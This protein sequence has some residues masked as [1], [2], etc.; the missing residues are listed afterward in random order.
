MSPGCAA[1]TWLHLCCVRFLLQVQAGGGKERVPFASRMIAFHTSSASRLSLPCAP[2]FLSTSFRPGL[3]AQ[4]P[5]SVAGPTWM[6]IR[7]DGVYLQRGKLQY[8]CVSVGKFSGRAR[9]TC[10]RATVVGQKAKFPHWLP[11]G[12]DRRTS[13]GGLVT[14]ESLGFCS[15][16]VVLASAFFRAFSEKDN[17]RICRCQGNIG[18]GI[19]MYHI[20]SVCSH[21]S[22]ARG[23]QSF[24]VFLG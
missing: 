11:D 1:T 6:W 8:S 17:P 15:G 21:N 5:L 4:L 18:V 23:Q 13:D 19:G 24:A 16:W 14:K 12:H 10:D 3:G 9:P 22:H 7:L 2:H 20:E